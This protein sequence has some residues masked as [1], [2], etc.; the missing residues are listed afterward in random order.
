MNKTII[1]TIGWMLLA[2][3]VGA[4]T[5]GEKYKLP[6]EAG[7]LRVDGV[8]HLPTSLL[9]DQKQDADAYFRFYPDGTFIVYHAG[10]SPESKPQVF[11]VNCNYQYITSTAAPFNQD[12]SLKQNGNIA[13]ARIVYPDKAVLL[14]FDVRKDVIAATVRTFDLEGKMTGQ[15]A[16]Y[17]MPFHQ[18]AWPVSEGK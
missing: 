16:K 15:P 7:E 12:Y 6:E 11:Q 2:L 5:L 10:V 13:R 9:A 4:Q 18:L 8:Y 1:M 14:E 17:V 3:G